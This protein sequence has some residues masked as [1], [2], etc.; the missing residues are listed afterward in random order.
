MGQAARIY[1]LDEFRKRKEAQA[2]APVAA[3][4]VVQPPVVWVW[5]VWWR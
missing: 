2:D 1:D 3:P 4:V 5:W